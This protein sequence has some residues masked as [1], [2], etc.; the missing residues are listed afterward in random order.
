MGVAWHCGSAVL[1]SATQH[2]VFMIPTYCPQTWEHV[3]VIA[4]TVKMLD[5]GGIGAGKPQLG[6]LKKD[7][8]FAVRCPTR[9]N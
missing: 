8:N 5:V 9:A 4:F 6:R 1:E 7:Y 3:G 2:A